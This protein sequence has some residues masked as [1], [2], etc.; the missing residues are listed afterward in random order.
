[1]APSDAVPP[2]TP[3][4]GA[5]SQH[6]LDESLQRLAELG[7]RGLSPAVLMMVQGWTRSLTTQ[8]EELSKSLDRSEQRVS[9]LEGELSKEKTRTAV[10][11][12]RL[13]SRPLHDAAIMVGSLSIGVALTTEAAALSAF[14]AAI[15]VVF[16][17]FGW[18]PAM[19]RTTS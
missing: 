2:A 12:E 13:A 4:V 15:G 16:L 14:L 8:N 11:L 19:R 9:R 17:V 1:V 6:P 10:L 7:A 5:I 3:A 18:A